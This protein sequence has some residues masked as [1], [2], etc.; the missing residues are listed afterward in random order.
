MILLSEGVSLEVPFIQTDNVDNV[1]VA[2]TITVEVECPSCEGE[3]EVPNL[4]GHYACP[5]CNGV[6]E[7]E[8]DDDASY[9]GDEDGL[10]WA[11]VTRQLVFA[12][13]VVLFVLFAFFAE[14]C[15]PGVPCGG[16]P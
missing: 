13:F 10:D 3:V 15:E 16:G 8:V 4:D 2:H 12:C 11:V 9:D 5:L 6:F 1:E 14:P 7:Y